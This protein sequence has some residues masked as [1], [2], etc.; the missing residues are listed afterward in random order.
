[1]RKTIY[2][3]RFLTGTEFDWVRNV[4]PVDTPEKAD[5]IVFSGGA[6]I[7]PNLYGC[8]RHPTTHFYQM[9]DDLEVNCFN[10]LSKDQVVIGLCRGAQLIT[11][12]NGGKLIQNVTGHCCGPHSIT[13]RDLSFK[14]E[15]IHH[16]MM[17]PFDMSK[18]DYDLLFWASK[19]RSS[20]YEG[21][22]IGIPPCEPEVILYH[23]KDLPT[24]LA[25][26]GHP[27]MMSHCQAHEVFND[28]LKTIIQYI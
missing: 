16:Q 22:K 20:I 8:E 18:E 25:I 28:I 5:I 13:N 10:K 1:M 27:E 14:I 4:T 11:A 19:N 2:C 24:C 7:N 15:S 23:K 21:D 12:L 3:P 9:R 6:D 26:Q 17:Y